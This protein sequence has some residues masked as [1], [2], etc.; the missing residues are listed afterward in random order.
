MCC[1]PHDEQSPL[2]RNDIT[3]N[4]S[5]QHHDN[6]ANPHPSSL[7]WQCLLLSLVL[8][9]ISCCTL[10][11]PSSHSPVTLPAAFSQSGTETVEAKWW[12]SF[13]DEQLDSLIEDALSDNF[14]LRAAYD[15][16]EQAQA[17]TDKAEAPLLPDL[18]ATAEGA[19]TSVQDPDTVS[20]TKEF[21]LGFETSYELDLWGQLRST[22]N[23]VT[24]S[25]EISR[26]DLQTAAISLSAE[27]AEQWYTLVEIQCQL[28]LL[29]KQMKTHRKGLQLI[30]TQFRAG[31]VPMAD[32]LQQRQLLAADH[33]QKIQ[34]VKNKLLKQNQ[35]TLLLGLPPGSRTFS[36]PPTLI[37]LPP[38]PATGIPADRLLN[39]P[40]VHSAMLEVQAADFRVAAAM[41]NRLPSLT[42][43]F[44]LES[45][46]TQVSDLF[47]PFF[48]SLVADIVAPLLD[49]GRRKA[50]VARTLA[51]SEEKLHLLEQTLLNA[52]GEV[53]Q[54]LITEQQQI[55]YQASLSEQLDLAG[56]TIQQIKM[57]Y[58]KGI[59]SY[60]RVLSALISKQNLEQSLLSAQKTL[61]LNRIQLCRALAS[62]WQ[63]SLPSTKPRETP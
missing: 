53:E 22:L 35:L 26:A 56:Q 20:S 41:A 13:H 4:T 39:R 55:H 48:A 49:G 12:H 18:T 8:P 42:F 23:A 16:L 32:I 27:V 15:R 63:L 46:S 3:M 14:T 43:S 40:D 51:V 30:T 5:L 11:E 7:T 10:P 54:A 58:L 36:L 62:S 9:F 2:Y 59:E 1:I 31:L 19:H 52:A 29:E 61:L 44:T 24:I 33:A 37:E 57:R 6:Q 38:L 25:R 50:E 60:E 17:L 34:L 21:Y 45:S 28:H 47:S